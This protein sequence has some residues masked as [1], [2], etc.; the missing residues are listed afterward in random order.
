MI[1]DNDKDK[2]RSHLG[3]VTMAHEYNESSTTDN[4]VSDIIKVYNAITTNKAA[5]QDRGA[6]I[7]RNTQ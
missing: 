4:E 7:W 1:S 6:F 5:S 3:T 2:G